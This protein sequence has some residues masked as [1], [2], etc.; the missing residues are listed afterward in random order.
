MIQRTQRSLLFGGTVLVLALLAT[1]AL[2]VDA[3]FS[4]SI[5]RFHYGYFTTFA[6]VAPEDQVVAAT[7]GATGPR[8]FTIANKAVD[9]GIISYTATF[10]GYP[11]FKGT[12]TRYMTAGDFS[13]S[14]KVPSA[15]YSIMRPN[16]FGGTQYP[17]ALPTTP[18]DGYMKVQVGPNGFGGFWGIYDGGTLT[19][20]LESMGAGGGYSDFLFRPSPFGA[21]AGLARG[22]DHDGGANNVYASNAQT[23][24][25]QYSLIT[26]Q[27]NPSQTG[28]QLGIRMAGFGHVTGMVTVSGPEGGY[29]TKVTYTGADGRTASGLMGTISMVAPG[30]II[31]YTMVNQPTFDQSTA[32]DAL[33]AAAPDVTISTLTFLPEPSQLVML[34]TGILGLVA[35]RGRLRG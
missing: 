21:V 9:G 8:G 10:P 33:F 17:N 30:L 1:P 13:R 23:R 19:G 6:T 16:T 5:N 2:A 32:V 31:Q 11:Y 15:T 27:T 26:N 22:L 29:A 7:Q 14:F 4:G 20:T 35:L 28:G 24:C 12:R 18:A 3:L 34:A 25:C